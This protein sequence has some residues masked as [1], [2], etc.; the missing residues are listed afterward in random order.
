MVRKCDFAKIDHREQG[1]RGKL[2]EMY[3]R[4]KEILF[5]LQK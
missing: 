5:R 1:D 4:D 3:F 2:R